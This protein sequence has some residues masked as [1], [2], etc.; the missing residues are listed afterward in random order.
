MCVLSIKVP[1]RKKSGNLFNDPRIFLHIYIYMCTYLNTHVYIWIIWYRY[2]YILYIYKCACMYTCMCVCV[3]VCVCE[4]VCVHVYVSLCAS[5]NKY[6]YVLWIISS[7]C[8]AVSMD[9][10]DPLSPLLPIVHR[11]FI[12][13]PSHHRT[14]MAQGPFLK[15]GPDAGPQPTRVR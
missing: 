11:F 6:S 12:Y 1:I 10:P 13:S 7:S 14:S 3:C 8:R 5:L 9:I 15:V 4:C 2:T